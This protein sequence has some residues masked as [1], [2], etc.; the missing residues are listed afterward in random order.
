MKV[1]IDKVFNRYLDKLARPEI[2]LLN[3][4][5]FAY[6]VCGYTGLILA[7]LLTM[8]LTIYQGLSL[9]VMIGIIGISVLTFLGLAM[10]TKIITAEE[11][12]IYYHH[13]IAVMVMAA[14]FLNILSQR[15][16]VYLDMMILGVGVFLI[17]GRIGCLMVG[18]CHGRPSKWGVCYRKEHVDAGFTPH[19][20]GVRLFPIQ[21][22]E[23]LWVFGIVLIGILFVLGGRDPGYVLAWY[24]ITYGIGRFIFEFARGD[25]ERP[26]Y[27]SFSEA[28]WISVI[29]MCVVVWV[30]FAGVLTFELW[31]IFATYGIVVTMVAVVLIRQFPGAL[32]YQLF[33]PNHVKEVA[34]TIQR[35]SH[36]A[37][38]GTASSEMKTNPQKIPIACTS[39]G[40]RI[41]AERIKND[42]G[43]IHHF[44]ISS[45]KRLM[46]DRT[47]MKLADLILK[48]K[49]PAGSGQVMKGNRGVFHLFIHPPG[50]NNGHSLVKSESQ[51]CKQDNPPN[52]RQE[53]V[54]GLLYS[55][56]R[57][58]VNT[59]LAF[60]ARSELTALINLLSEKKIIATE[61]LEEK[62][63]TAAKELGQKL[64]EGGVGVI[65][66]DPAPNKYSLKNGEKVDCAN[67]IH[68]CRAACCRLS[69]ALSGQDVQEG[70]VRWNLGQPYMIAHDEDGYCAHLDRASLTCK[71]YEHQP[72]TCQTYHCRNDGRIWLDFEKMIINPDLKRADWPGCVKTEK[73][74]DT[75]HDKKAV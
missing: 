67:R 65:L 35:L 56:G 24:V 43:N 5:L 34:E 32:K 30:E 72:V 15:V 40:I 45:Q 62:K 3:R 1:L 63:E 48:L 42:K 53:F 59:Q 73:A 26:Y 21:V 6:Q 41:S 20:L 22:V 28:Q 10:V 25:P 4:N 75:V 27:W 7:I 2:R 12:I 19:Y 33:L 36:C 44:A 29:L 39:Q 57:L 58:N 74:E 68:L 71:I 9:W 61:E 49:Y 38:G 18:C 14:V 31:H 60:E 11:R 51:Y 70:I 47:A 46:T 16:L 52:L 50:R 64:Q 69:F 55:H 37:V 8:I 17:F 13:Q 54:N 66:Q 23:S